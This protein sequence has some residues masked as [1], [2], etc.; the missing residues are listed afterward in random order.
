[1]N[2]NTSHRLITISS[3]NNLSQERIKIPFIYLFVFFESLF[4]KRKFE[5]EATIMIFLKDRI[6]AKKTSLENG[7]QWAWHRSHDGH[8]GGTS[9]FHELLSVSG[10]REKI[11][12]ECLLP[13]LASTSEKISSGVLVKRNQHRVSLI[14]NFVTPS[15]STL[16]CCRSMETLD[17]K[18][19]IFR[20]ILVEGWKRTGDCAVSAELVVRRRINFIVEILL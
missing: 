16:N 17:S 7:W 6:F 4:E 3:H 15:S 20:R 12:E 10:Y 14:S 8:N 5:D 13:D 11:A 18:V 2:T 9:R 1:M 19:R